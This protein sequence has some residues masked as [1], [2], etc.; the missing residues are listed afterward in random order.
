MVAESSLALRKK[1]LPQG[2]VNQSA[3]QP[4]WRPLEIPLPGKALRPENIIRICAALNISTDYLLLG[5][6][7]NTD[8]SHISQK[9]SVLSP[10]QY[11]HLEDIINSFIAAVNHED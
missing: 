10:E 8:Y 6:T 11:R 4:A 5:E 7:S 2:I 9:L 1:N 3:G